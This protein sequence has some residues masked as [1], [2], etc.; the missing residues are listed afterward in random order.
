M[1]YCGGSHF[2]TTS[3]PLFSS[4]SIELTF[5]LWHR[6]PC[7]TRCDFPFLH[8]PC[9][10]TGLVSL[11][12]AFPSLLPTHSFSLLCLPRGPIHKIPASQEALPQVDIAGNPTP[13][14]PALDSAV[15]KITSVPCCSHLPALTTNLHNSLSPLLSAPHPHPSQKPHAGMDPSA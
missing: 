2:N 9:L 13:S 11:L 6:L 4:F 14:C 5:K 10:L 8:L 12:A 3:P 1:P 7:Q 15:K